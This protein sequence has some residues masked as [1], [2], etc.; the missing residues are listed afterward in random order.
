MAIKNKH[1]FKDIEN[2]AQKEALTNEI[3][4]NL[5]EFLVA[6]FLARS[7]NIEGEFLSRC[8]KGLLSS[9]REYE[10]WLRKNQKELLTHLPKL[11]QSTASEIKSYLLNMNDSHPREIVLVGKIAG[12]FHSD[13]FHEAD[14]IALYQDKIKPISLKLCKNKAYLNTKS[15]G[16]K[17]FFLKY[18]SAF[19]DAEFYQNTF[20]QMIDD[21]FDNFGQ[22][23]YSRRGL[24]FS[25][26]FDK[27]W[28]FGDLPG[29]LKGED[30]EDLKNFYQ[31][32]L[33][34][35]HQMTQTLYHEDSSK[36]KSCLHALMGYSSQEILQSICYYKKIDKVPYQLAKTFVHDPLEIKNI[37]IEEY[38][39]HKTSFNIFI[40]ESILQLRVK[41]MNKFTTKSY[42]INC[43]I[44]Y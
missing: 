5:F 25:G 39:D 8:D 32:I 35:L 42:K 27:S 38:S 28:V 33:K 37:T 31:I 23:L 20:N 26:S 18:F 7:F 13:E 17:S 44:L 30:K 21:G 43:S 4:G 9:F 34:N 15:A 6:Q 24:D 3:K 29:K 36:F 2:T 19:K 16:S 22:S 40:D 10:V 1:N 41:P 14:I 12:G 11:A